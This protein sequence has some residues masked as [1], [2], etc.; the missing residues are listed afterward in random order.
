MKKIIFITAIAFNS[1]FV[2][3]QESD[4][5][6]KLHAANIGFGGFS[7]KKA[8]YEGGGAAFVADLTA[9]I[10]KNLISASYVNGAEIGLIDTSSYQFYE[11]SMLY[12]REW[13]ATKWLR[14]EGFAGIGYYNQDVDDVADEGIPDDKSVSF[15][16]RIN[17]KFYFSKIFGM[18][19]NTNYSINS[20]NNNFS[21]NL[22]F[23]YR[24]N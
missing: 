12:G 22:I 24:L 20:V 23:H 15:P 1:F 18:G 10:N 5:Q 8:N 17:S 9:S 4:S 3:A 13:E 11:F 6:L 19:L 2:N 16:L 21:T 7:F 14:F